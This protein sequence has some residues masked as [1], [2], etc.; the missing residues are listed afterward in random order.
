MCHSR[1][2]TN[3][4]WLCT[5]DGCVGENYAKGRCLSH[6]AREAR[7]T[8]QAPITTQPLSERDWVGNG[9]AIASW[10]LFCDLNTLLSTL[11]DVEQRV[12]VCLY[13]MGLTLTETGRV[14]RFNHVVPHERVRQIEAKAL[15][16]L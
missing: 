11:S 4:I 2:H 9:E 5:V 6:Y 14:C 15:R 7:G 16:K 3:G 13:W 10:S 1:N 12:L 8:L